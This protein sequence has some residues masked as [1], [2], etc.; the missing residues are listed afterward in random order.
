M[1]RLYLNTEDHNKIYHNEQLY[2]ANDCS[3]GDNGAA[4]WMNMGV[5]SQKIRIQCRVQQH[6][7]LTVAANMAI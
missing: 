2:K 7:V 4:L 5:K 1:S 3:F 6:T